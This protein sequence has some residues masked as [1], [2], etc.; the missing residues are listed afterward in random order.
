MSAVP[1]TGCRVGEVTL[2][3]LPDAVGLLAACDE[4]YPDVP[5]ERWD[6][7]RPEYPEL[8]AGRYWRLPVACTVI[9]AHGR[10]LLVD[11]GVGPPGLWS[12]DGEREGMLPAALADEGFD[13]DAVFFS[14]LH[15]DHVGWLADPALFDRVRIL[16]HADA[17]AY[18]LEHT[19]VE[20]L[21]DRLRALREAGRIE[22][23]AAGDDLL[24]GA[25]AVAYPGHYPG[26]LGVEITSNGSRAL[27]IADAAPHP[28]LLD[29]PDWHF[30]Y[31][32]D[33]ALASR[34]RAALVGS[35]VDTDTLVVCG[36]YP[37]GGIGRVERRDGRVLWEA[38]A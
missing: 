34:T 15:V 2:T 24:P 10:T 12:W 20:W 1:S 5:I 6:P 21:P 22:T 14:H 11:A 9:Q 29:H 7:F 30:R 25:R 32:H 13:L 38:A 16:V 17:L 23:V 3:A 27:L 36:H 31:D 18:A 4:A 28:A 37:D 33:A 8:F 26:H 35:V 19:S